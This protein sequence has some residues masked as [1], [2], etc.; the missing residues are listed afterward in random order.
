MDLDQQT[1]YEDNHLLIV[2]KP[3]GLLS[4]G[5]HTGDPNLFD[6]LKAHLKSKYQK[7]GNVYLAL[8]HRLDRPVGGL[9]IFSKTSK[10]AERLH[11][12]ML[13]GAIAKKYL[14]V[15][16]GYPGSDQGDW[17]HYIEKDEKKNKSRVFATPREGAKRCA[18]HYQVLANVDNRSLLEI[19]LDTGRSHQ[20]RAQLAFESCPIVADSKYGAGRRE[21][22]NSLA[23][24]A[25]SLDF[26][27]PVT[28][29]PLSLRVY[30]ET[31]T[32]WRPFTGFFPRSSS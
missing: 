24:F 19:V 31:G 1:I 25:Y 14:V 21:S 7:P 6:L 11:K 2:N 15:C 20:I 32:I 17:Q 16:E 30:P 5:D 26:E 28:H 9:I 29:E 18:L 3:V 13:Q 12:M 22:G 27:H 10:A 4:Q 8:I 23:L